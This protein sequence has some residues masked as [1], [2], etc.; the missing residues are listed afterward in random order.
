VLPPGYTLRTRTFTRYPAI[1]QTCQEINEEATSILYSCLKAGVEINLSAIFGFGIAKQA[2]LSFDASN[3]QLWNRETGRKVRVYEMA[4]Y[5]EFKS[6]SSSE[7]SRINSNFSDSLPRSLSLKP[8]YNP[9][10]ARSQ[11]KP[12][13]VNFKYYD[14]APKSSGFITK[15]TRPSGSVQ[16]PSAPLATPNILASRARAVDIVF[17]CSYGLLARG[18]RYIPSEW[19]RA[20]SAFIYDNLRRQLSKNEQLRK[21]CFDL[22][23]DF[24]EGWHVTLV[25]K[26]LFKTLKRLAK[27]LNRS[28]NAICFEV[29]GFFRCEIADF[30][31]SWKWQRLIARLEDNLVF[32]EY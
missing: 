25:V 13:S 30:K 14:I 17:I 27:K 22:K 21:I 7:S 28:S 11:Q 18:Q 8:Y 2:E 16:E 12:S 9:Y 15:S 10:S 20:V 5:E 29:K 31:Q 3:V 24:S 1:L 26:V 6:E 4:M 19:V 32:T 23:R